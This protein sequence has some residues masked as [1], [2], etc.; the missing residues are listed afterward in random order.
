MERENQIP[1]LYFV[2]GVL[3]RTL[4]VA[5]LDIAAIFFLA[6]ISSLGLMALVAG[7]VGQVVAGAL[8]FRRHREKSAEVLAWGWAL[9]VP[10][11]VGAALL[12]WLISTCKGF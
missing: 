10:P 8:I 1:P 7:L 2:V 4:V 6:S 9:V 5:A 11:L 12:G 3:A